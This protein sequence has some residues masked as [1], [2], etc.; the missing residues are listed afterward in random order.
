[1]FLIDQIDVTGSSDFTFSLDMLAHHYDD[2]DS[3][4]E[5]L[6]TYSI[7][8]GTFQNLLWVQNTGES[9]NDPAAIDTDFDGD[10]NCGANTTLPSLTIGTGTDGCVVSSSNFANFS[11]STISLSSN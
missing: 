3:D 10:G 1:M 9:F 6:I 11:S 7:H 8:G 2:W 4:D 5:L